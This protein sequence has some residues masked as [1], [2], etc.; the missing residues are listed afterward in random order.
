MSDK[1]TNEP[2]NANEPAQNAPEQAQKVYTIDALAE[3]V[4]KR[5][6]ISSDRAAKRIR[7]F[8]R[9][10][11]SELGANDQAVR[12]HRKGDAWQP[13]NATT[14]RA[15]ITRRTADESRVQSA[16]VAELA[17]ESNES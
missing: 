12:D 7:A 14:A 6:G 17:N 5:D 8:L 11:K 13:L 9:S 15:V 2:Q 1:G 4:G 3:Y 10:N 16:D